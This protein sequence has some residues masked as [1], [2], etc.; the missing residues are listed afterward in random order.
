VLNTVAF[1]KQVE[2]RWRK[3]R[4]ARQARHLSNEVDA[5][6]VDALEAAVVEAY[7]RL[8]HRYY[9]LKAK[10]MGVRPRPLGPQRAARDGR[11]AHL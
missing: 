6:A 5:D 4:R 7:P 1:E 8:S 11:A 9:R 3:L 10:V 2:D